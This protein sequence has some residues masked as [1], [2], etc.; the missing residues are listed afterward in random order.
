VEIIEEDMADKY[1]L[2]VIGS[3]PG[4]YVAAIRAAQMGMKTACIERAE[5]GG[6][7]LN[8]GCIPTKALLHSASLYHEMQRADDFGI[9]A[10]NIGVDLKKMVKHSRSTAGRLSKGVEYLFKKNKIDY[11]NGQGEITGQGRVKV[12]DSKGESQTLEAKNILI[13]T[14]ARPRTIPGLEFDGKQIITSKEAMILENKPDHLIVI[15]A[16]AIG[17][18]FAYFYSTIGVKVTLIEMMDQILPIEDPEV[19]QTVHSFFKK[20]GIKVLTST[21]VDK[22][23]KA[24]NSVTVTV[25]TN[26]KTETIKGD[27]T[28]VAIGV[29]GNIENLGLENLGVKVE[30]GAIMVD[31]TTYETHVKGIYAIGDVIGPPWLAHVASQEAINAVEIMAGHQPQAIDYDFIPGCTYCQ[32]QVASMGLTEKEAEK[33]GYQIKVGKFPFRPNGKS[34]AMGH[35]TGFVKLVF[36]AKYGELL[37]AHIVGSEATEMV[38][39]LGVAKT[40]ETTADEIINTIH[41]H[42]TVSETIKEAAEA[43]FGKAI[44]I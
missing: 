28:L 22:V 44:H 4:G 5:V 8:W 11:Y 13:A 14:G 17:V 23:D 19:A 32:P 20:Q 16:G 10:D 43:A 29:T 1:D 27:V 2:V 33:R 35:T 36:D 42:P 26:G 12:I 9:H 34:L 30:R 25:S 37:G 15:G 40:L 6:I 38:A 24:K 18:E 31:K 21:K 39:E 7:C 3:G 41:A